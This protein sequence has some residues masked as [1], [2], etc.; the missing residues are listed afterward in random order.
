MK[1]RV[2]NRA[3]QL[4]G[5]CRS[6]FSRRKELTAKLVKNPF[7][8]ILFIGE[9][10]KVSVIAYAQTGAFLTPVVLHLAAAAIV[11]TTLWLLAEVIMK[12]ASEYVSDAA[13]KG[14]DKLEEATGG[15]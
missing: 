4:Y 10:I 15:D 11:V 13:D 7:F 14:K 2:T 3:K 12:E 1:E 6:V 9:A 5:G 8:P